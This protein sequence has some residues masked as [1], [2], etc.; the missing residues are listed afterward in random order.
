MKH[1]YIR[2]LNI[3]YQGMPVIKDLNIE[4]PSTGIVHISGPSG[5]GKTTLLQAIAG[6]VE[7][8][9]TIETGLENGERLSYV[10]QDDRLLPWFSARTN[11]A[12]TASGSIDKKDT[13][14]IAEKWLSEL[15]L[16]NDMDKHPDELSGGM[17]QRVNIAR[18]LVN[19]ARIILLDEPFKGLDAIL[20][21]K[22]EAIFN[23]LSKEKLL[24]MVTHE[25]A[26]E[27]NTS[28]SVKLDK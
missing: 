28:L 3:S 5:C 25:P 23:E 22:V 2:N 21:S 26:N 17:R 6:L 27:T 19:D 14:L 9:G 7:Y 16:A 10:F 24:V 18:A 13:L 15:G 20:K 11:A 12:L 8:E 1:F 4:F